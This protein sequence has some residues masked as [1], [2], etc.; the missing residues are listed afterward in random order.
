MFADN[1]NAGRIQS[2]VSNNVKF[3]ACGNTKKNM[4]KLLGE[5]PVLNSNA[6]VVSA[7]VVRI[8]DLEKQGYKLIK[9]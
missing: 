4:A 7:G 5:E 2:L 1:D 9:P 6:T 8:I 3:S